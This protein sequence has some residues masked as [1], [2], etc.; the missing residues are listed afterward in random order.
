MQGNGEH[1]AN[2]KALPAV[3]R[4]TGFASPFD[5]AAWFDRL[6]AHGF[7]SGGRFD[8]CGAA[9]DTTAWLP[10][11]VEKPGE[12]AGLT[13]WYSFAIRPLYVGEKGR[14]AALKDLFARLRKRA[15][16]LTLYPVSDAEQD[17]IAA[18]MRDAGWWV[19]TAPRGDRHWLDLA[20][21][22]HDG[23]WESRPGALRNTVKRKAKKSVVDIALLTAFDPDA[24]AAS[25]EIYAAS[26]K[27]QEGDPALLRAFAEADSEP[28]TVRTGPHRI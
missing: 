9:G 8:A 20:G 10:L 16:R 28:G 17:G 1:R 4:G 11:R 25:E 19:R 24:W 12:L 23:W 3:A 18:A 22:D 14:A 21:L 13:N 2:D 7:A 6:A 5:R 15:A 27:T 26:W